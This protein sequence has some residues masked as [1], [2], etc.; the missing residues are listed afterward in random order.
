[1]ANWDGVLDQIAAEQ[2]RIA[3]MLLGEGETAIAAIEAVVAGI[4]LDS[5]ADAADARHQAR[6]L[7]AEDAIASLATHDPC[8]LAAPEAESGP[9]SCIEDDDLSAAGVTHAELEQMISG[10]Q[11]HR[12]REWLEGL[13]PQLRV[14]FVL[15]A[16]AGLNSSEVAGL[17]SR[18]GGDEAKNWTADS[19]RISFR[20]ALC[21]LASQLIHLTAAR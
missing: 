11:S 13:A 6:T 3:S 15:R 10:P 1:M 8:S 18:N 20:Q 9:V 17:I 12:L 7:L 16:V 2:Y 4:D 14:I 21:S 5:C 19:V